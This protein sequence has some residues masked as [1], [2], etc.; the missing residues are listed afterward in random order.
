MCAPC[1]I[2][3]DHPGALAGSARLLAAKKKHLAPEANYLATIAEWSAKSLLHGFVHGFEGDH[4]FTPALRDEAHAFAELGCRRAALLRNSAG[5][6]PEGSAPEFF[7][8]NGQLLVQWA[9]E[10]RLHTTKLIGGEY[11]GAWEIDGVTGIR[12][13]SEREGE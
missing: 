4:E 12:L 13:K 2:I 7:E 3:I 5:Y 11:Q 1:K 6:P 9:E 8:P 10:L